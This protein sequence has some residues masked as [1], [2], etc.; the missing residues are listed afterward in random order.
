MYKVYKVIYLLKIE[1]FLEK[2][3]NNKK[4][5]GSYKNRVFFEKNN[6]SLSGVVC[7]SRPDISPQKKYILGLGPGCGPEAKPK[8]KIG[9]IV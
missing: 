9:L 6:T 7:L 8:T 1:F 3:T 2:E 5:Y 4:I